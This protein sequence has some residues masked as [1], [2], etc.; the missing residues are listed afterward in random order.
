MLNVTFYFR[1]QRGLALQEDRGAHSVPRARVILEKAFGIEDEVLE[2]VVVMDR[3]I[4]LAWLRL[5]L[6]VAAILV[7]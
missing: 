7:R 2:R 4:G 3:L 1:L 6:A 5:A